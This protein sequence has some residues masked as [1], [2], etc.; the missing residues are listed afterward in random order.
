MTDDPP[1]A[2]AAPAA[3]AGAEGHLD[4]SARAFQLGLAGGTAL[5]LLAAAATLAGPPEA[6]GGLQP[7]YP[8]VIAFE[9][10]RTPA[11]L[12][13]LFGDGPSACR[14]ALV[15]A[16]D[17]INVL[18]LALF[19]PAY[20]ALLAGLFAGLGRRSA[21]RRPALARAGLALTGAAV[22]A[23][24]AENLCLLG[25]TPELDAT[26]TS[27]AVLPIA[28]GAKWL[29]LGVGSALGGLALGTGAWPSPTPGRARLPSWAAA[30]ILACSGAAVLGATAAIASP[31]LFGRHL[32][33]SIAVSWLPLLAA[34][35]LGS[36]P[37]RLRRRA[38]GRSARALR[39]HAP[40]E[41]YTAVREELA[42]GDIVCF[43]GK[44]LMSATIRALTRSPYS[45]AGL[46]FRFEDRVYC[47]E[48]VGAG[49]RLIPLSQL[50]REYTGGIDH[51]VVRAS[52]EV[53]AKA[54]SFAFPQ[55][56]RRYDLRGIFW[57]ATAIILDWKPKRRRDGAWFCSEL[58]AEA[59]R[60]QGLPLS[61]E[62]PWYVSPAAIALSPNLHLA[63]VLKRE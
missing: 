25:L 43:R 42:T 2:P 21:W 50:V 32:E 8:P 40:A 37:R 26:S 48:A 19:I 7:G 24:V 44:G 20:A 47:L 54:L 55:L 58:V 6:C 31:A 51:F 46:L 57:F 22:S 18:D 52:K 16:M 29:A 34:C 53:R 3:A 35:A 15:S 12:T 49:V 39:S 62:A 38:T 36:R 41:R 33:L 63:R 17:R 45:H 59:Y 27:L 28:T 61:E 14:E 30:A 10:A 23:D 1:P 56:G 11:D 9:L 5:V 13:A 4:D 60:R